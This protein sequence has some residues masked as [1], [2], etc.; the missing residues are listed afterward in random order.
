MLSGVQGRRRDNLLFLAVLAIGVAL[1]LHGIAFGLPAL[2]DPDELMF[3]MGATKMLTGGAMNPGWF[4]HPAT[5]TMYVLALVNS[6]TFGVGWLLGSFSTPTEYL[7]VIYKDP[8]IVIL[9][10]RLAIALFAMV[11]IWQVWRMGRDLGG[12][13]A[14]LIAALLLAS[15]P[16]HVTY[17]QIIRS[18]MMGTVFLLM[19]ISAALRIAR[20]GKAADY[21]WAALA[22]ALAVSS[23]WPFAIAGAAVA[24]AVAVRLFERGRIARA[25]LRNFGAFLVLAPILLVLIS[26]YL[27]LDHQTVLRNLTGEARTQ[28]LGATGGGFLD[29]AWWYLS[30]PL[31]NGLGAIGL[32][33]AGAGLVVM[34]RTR[35]IAWAVLPVLVAHILIICLHGLRW[36]RWV[37][38]VLPLLALA[39]GLAGAAGIRMAQARWPSGRAGVLAGALMCTAPILLIPSAW[40]KAAARTNDTRQAATRWAATHVPPGSVVMIEHFAFDVV[41]QPWTVIFPMGDAGCIDAKAMLDGKTDY[42]EI[43]A[44]RGARSNV[45]YGTVARSR[46]ATCRADYAILMEMARYQDER[47]RF[48]AQAAAYDALLRDMKIEAIFRPEPDKRA[49]PVMIVL[50]AKSAPD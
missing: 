1:R 32:A 41:S 3:E 7:Q 10:G 23:K 15:S 34:T 28:H 13:I 18:D 11:T 14:G 48:P 20:D 37:L 36:E 17:S 12:P 47:A 39:A 16:V 46:R 8:S 22:L 45:D 35:A 4:G 26:P 5:T 27:V 2:N 44:A 6:A 31:L 24:G 43:E 33:L 29:N 50:K 21:R 38:P 9:P 40:T 49:G 30:G 42:R 25:D 19:T